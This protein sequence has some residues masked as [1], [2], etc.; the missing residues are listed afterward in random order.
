MFQF[1]LRFFL[2]ALLRFIT[3]VLIAL[4][5]HDSIIRPYVGDFLVVILMYCAVK[6]FVKISSIKLAIGVLLFACIIE[7]LQYFNFVKI[8]HLENNKLAKTILGYGFEWIDIL[9]YTLGTI[10]IFLI[11][12]NYTKRNNLRNP[13]SNPQN[14]R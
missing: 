9:A 1:S 4:Y 10:T 5:V 2:A 13:S 3:E 12:S 6:A 14:P 11:D 8:I 7:T